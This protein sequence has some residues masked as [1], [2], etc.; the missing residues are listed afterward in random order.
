MLTINE[1][2]REIE[3]HFADYLKPAFQDVKI[4]ICPAHRTNCV[5]SGIRLIP[6]QT[7]NG[8]IP[9]IYLEDMYEYYLDNGNLNDTFTAFAMF[10][11]NCPRHMEDY[12]AVFTSEYI[13][14]HVFV[15]LI[16]RKKNEALL[17]QIPHAD[18]LDLAAVFRVRVDL[19]GD[20]QY[21][22]YL[23]TYEI[24]KLCH[25]DLITITRK[26]CQNYISILGQF[27]IIGVED[28]FLSRINMPDTDFNKPSMYL[29]LNESQIY[30]A[31]AMF[32]CPDI[33]RR[34]STQLDS[35]LIILPSSIH[36][37]IIVEADSIIKKMGKEAIYEMVSDVNQVCVEKEEFL[38]DTVYVYS[39]KH[40]FDI[41]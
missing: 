33:F 40:G 2:Q 39:R 1:F 37:L 19:D 7:C 13:L 27:H 35:D 18:F 34:I 15:Q 41:L 9:L 29:M 20:K 3:K 28:M 38:S 30:G 22:S 6:K 36:E 21:T 11:K 24:M 25:L 4:Q 16:N 23:L 12:S 17:T 26:A 32:A 14:D 8:A 31:A 10:V 5:K